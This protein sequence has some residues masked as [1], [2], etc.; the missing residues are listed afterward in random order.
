MLLSYATG[1]LRYYDC[2]F[3]V[4]DLYDTNLNKVK[5][6]F[7]KSMMPELGDK[8][9]S[10][11]GQKGVCGMLLPQEDMPHT[12]NGI[13]PDIIINPHAFPSRMTIAHLIESVLAKLGCIKGSYIDGTPFENHCIEDYYDML[14]KYGYQKR[15]DE[16]MYNGYT[17]EQIKTE[18]FK[19]KARNFIFPPRNIEQLKKNR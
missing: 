15:G 10:T 13:V 6:R 18:I 8:M 5:I 19:M 7:R 1:I 14:G 12:K 17:G 9:S 16:I 4:Y 11:H 2:G 3:H